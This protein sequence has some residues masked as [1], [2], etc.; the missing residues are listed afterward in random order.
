M[1]D[2]KLSHPYVSNSRRWEGPF[3]PK[4]VEDLYIRM[5]SE[6]FYNNNY[7][8]DSW[9]PHP[10]ELMCNMLIDCFD[11]RASSRI[12]DFGCGVGY[13]LQGF[14]KRGIPCFGIEFSKDIFER[15]HPDVRENVQLLTSF[16]PTKPA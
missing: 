8:L 12:L 11:L 1:E 13:L 5:M 9:N 6:N 14:S 2:S 15:I 7:N 10:Y 4:Q 16:V 3:S